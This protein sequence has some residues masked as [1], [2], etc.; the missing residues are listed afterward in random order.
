MHARSTI[1]DGRSRHSPLQLAGRR[2]AQRRTYERTLLPVRY[3]ISKTT[4]RDGPQCGQDLIDPHGNSA[5][6]TGPEAGSIT[7]P[8]SSWSCSWTAAAIPPRQHLLDPARSRVKLVQRS[9]QVSQA[10][11]W[12]RIAAR[13]VAEDHITRAFA[14]SQSC[15]R[16]SARHTVHLERRC[17]FTVSTPVIE[18]SRQSSYYVQ[19]CLRHS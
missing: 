1:P 11:L 15:R 9:K 19:I 5:E 8:R 16:N 2:S 4:L 7:L 18:Q 14:S 10:A 3:F 6:S 13:V 17:G 12:R